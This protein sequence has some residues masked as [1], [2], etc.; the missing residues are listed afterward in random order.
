LAAAGIA[1][2]EPARDGAAGTGTADGGPDR[3]P[4][5]ALSYQDQAD[6]YQAHQA[7]PRP[8]LV[9]G[10]DGR[11]AL[12]VAVP[13]GRITAARWRLLAGTAARDGSGALRVTPWRGVVLPGFTADGGARAL[14][15]LSD[16]GLV[17]DAASPWRGAGACAG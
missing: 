12:S 2:A 15:D 1:C 4:P 16:A 14:R 3:V 11:R 8:G 17:A 7:G 9:V 6:Q 13:L 10:P 5:A